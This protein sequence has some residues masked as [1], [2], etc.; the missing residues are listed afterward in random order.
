[1]FSLGF[2]SRNLHAFAVHA[3]ISRLSMGIL[4]LTLLVCTMVDG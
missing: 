1:M 3:D 4:L 2:L